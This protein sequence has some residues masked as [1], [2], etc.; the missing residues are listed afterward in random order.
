MAWL[1]KAILDLTNAQYAPE[2]QI[3]ED[4]KDFV[5]ENTWNTPFVIK[6]GR[7]NH[8]KSIVLCLLDTMNVYTVI[9]EDEDEIE[10]VQ[11]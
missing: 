9:D 2:S 6:V 5:I 11:I 7:N 8:I 4:V 1:E 3:T 10:V